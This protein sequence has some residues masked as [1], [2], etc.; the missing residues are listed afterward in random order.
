M[1][2]DADF[3]SLQSDRK[4]WIEKQSQGMDPP[5]IEDFF[6]GEPIVTMSSMAGIDINGERQQK[7]IQQRQA[8][9]S[10]SI[11]MWMQTQTSQIMD[12]HSRFHQECLDFGEWVRVK[13]YSPHDKT[14]SK[15]RTL[16]RMSYPDA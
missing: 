16:V 12:S 14:F 13:D 8:E 9:I 1:D 2:L 15:I 5:Q 7:E 4:S 3:V 10:A 11:P 6:P